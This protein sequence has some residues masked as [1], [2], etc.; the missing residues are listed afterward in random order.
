MFSTA[1]PNIDEYLLN[2]VTKHNPDVIVVCGWIYWPYTR[3]INA[4]AL[5]PVA[6]ILGMDSPWRATLAQRF[7]RLRLSGVVPHLHLVVTASDRTAE[8]ARRIGVPAERL[9]SGFY[10]FDYTRFAEAARSR[11]SPWP[12]Q[13][14]FAARYAPEKNVAT[15]LRAYERYRASLPS[16]WGLTCVGAGPDGALIRSAAGVEDRGFVQPSAL[17]ALFASHGAFVL[18]STFEPWGV[19]IAEAAGAALPVICSSACGAARDIVRPYYNGM[20][21]EPND[22]TGWT[23]A[24]QWLHEHEPELPE[25]GRRGQA[26]AEAFSAESWAVRWHNYFLDAIALQQRQA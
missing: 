18:P 15:L 12:R 6:K 24:M 14:L 1:L 2:A 4:R 22:T 10:G 20:I 23:R 9:R 5:A 25:I 21:V 3:L 11:P 19:V 16:P 7:A 13:F 17:P 26:L 8:Y